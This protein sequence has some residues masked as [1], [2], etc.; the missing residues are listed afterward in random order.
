M[1]ILRIKACEAILVVIKK[2]NYEPEHEHYVSFKI[3]LRVTLSVWGDRD[4]ADA[5]HI[6]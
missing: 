4:D 3:T 5:F 2:N 1:C 6:Q